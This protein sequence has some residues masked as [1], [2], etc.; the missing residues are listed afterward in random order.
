M[1]NS[2]NNAVANFVMEDVALNV[3]YKIGT[4]G[5]TNLAAVTRSGVVH[6]YKHTLNGKCGKPLKPKTTIQIASDNSENKSTIISPIP[7]INVAFKNDAS[8]MLCH[9]FLSLLVFEDVVSSDDVCCKIF[10]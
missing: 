8:L 5:T 9:G 7:V 1:E 2:N 3:S 6:V 10:L 4:N